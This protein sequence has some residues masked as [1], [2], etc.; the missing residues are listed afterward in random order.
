V[1]CDAVSRL[2]DSSFIF[3]RKAGR[4]AGSAGRRQRRQRPA[5]RSRTCMIMIRLEACACRHITHQSHGGMGAWGHEGM[6]AGGS[7]DQLI[8]KSAVSPISAY[9][10][11][12]TRHLHHCCGLW[13][14]AMEILTDGDDEYYHLHNLAVWWERTT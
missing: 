9:M 13:M 8:N 4:Q 1:T 14:P 2:I 3:E 11:A 5:K 7:A 6:R 12:P 10:L